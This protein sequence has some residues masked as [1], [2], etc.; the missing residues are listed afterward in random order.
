MFGKKVVED[1]RK[2]DSG[3]QEVELFPGISWRKQKCFESAMV[4]LFC[5][6]GYICYK[7]LDKLSSSTMEKGDSR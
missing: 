1:L 4:M 5:S 3:K 6:H 2:E 7:I